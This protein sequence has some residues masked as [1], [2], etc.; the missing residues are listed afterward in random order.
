MR[1]PWKQ[2]I[3]VVQQAEA[4]LNAAK[5]ATDCNQLKTAVETFVVAMDGTTDDGAAVLGDG[6]LCQLAGDALLRRG[7]PL[8]WIIMLAQRVPHE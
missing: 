4:L 6:D 1:G 5:S 2:Q 8:D 3:I 7:K